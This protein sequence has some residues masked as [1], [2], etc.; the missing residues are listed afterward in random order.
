MRPFGAFLYVFFIL[1]GFLVVLFIFGETGLL[2]G[3]QYQFNKETA[4]NKEEIIVSDSITNPIF[5]SLKTEV[6][7]TLNAQV[8]DSIR[9]NNISGKSGECGL[10][11]PSGDLAVLN[12]FFE[13]LK[14]PDSSQSPLRILY[15]GD[16]QI[17]G[18]RIT[19][20][21]RRQFQQKFGGAGIGLIAPDLL[22]NLTHSFSVERS[23]NWSIINFTD[24]NDS[25][26]NRSLVF[27]SA[28]LPSGKEGWFKIRQIRNKENKN[29]YLKLRTVY[30]SPG[31]FD[32]IVKSEGKI[33][34]TEKVDKTASVST[35]DF[36]FNFT[37]PSVELYFQS[38]DSLEIS[39]FLLETRSGI[40]VDN[41]ALRGLSFPPFSKSDEQA[42][43]ET[44]KL[45]NPGLCVLHYG[46]NIA[47][48]ILGNFNNYRTRL[49]REIK[50]MQQLFPGVPVLIVGISDMAKKEN[51]QMISYP[52]IK[53]I[54]DVQFEAAQIC[55]CVFWDLEK[56]MG[57]PGSMTAWVN[58]SPRLGQKDY[59]HF[60]PEGTEK[61]GNRLSE[62]IL[63]EYEK[64]LQTKVSE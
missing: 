11:F 40:H 10:Q 28:V 60:T 50:K 47:P 35:L 63:A 15:F 38:T 49:I 52:N 24:L 57:G 12:P 25:L 34:Y 21:I 23:E 29:D 48:Q 42:M 61:I 39:A 8:P 18:D 5:D 13:K 64:Y 14:N 32:V 22:Y 4:G 2:K 33:I 36:N 16:S 31:D 6:L 1:S 54:R 3:G 19:S 59:V 37:P 45:I 46:V 55:N 27:K 51:G 62:L 41:I 43:E 58:G 30:S 7:D 9:Q 26:K 17:E 20:T 44:A 56:F 53:A